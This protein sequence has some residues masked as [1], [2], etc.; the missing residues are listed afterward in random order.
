MFG[1]GRELKVSKQ[2][3]FAGVI[4]V[5][6]VAVGYLVGLRNNGAFRDLSDIYV[7]TAGH[8]KAYVL[9]AHLLRKGN[10]EEALKLADAM[11][12]VGAS[13]LNP[14]PRELDPE[15]K[16]HLANVLSAVHEYRQA[17]P[18]PIAVLHR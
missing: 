4:A 15:D 2:L 1:K 16:A 18:S 10:Q 7:A 3:I 14:V 12:D 8:T 9:I 13:R 6:G 11:I 5:L 17:R